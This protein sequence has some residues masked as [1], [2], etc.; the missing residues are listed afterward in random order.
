MVSMELIRLTQIGLQ[1]ANTLVLCSGTELFA[2]GRCMDGRV[3]RRS[4][5]QVP[6]SMERIGLRRC[7][8]DEATQKVCRHNLGM[9]AI[10]LFVDVRSDVYVHRVSP[11]M[12]LYLSVVG[13]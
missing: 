5:V 7:L 1:I 3:L 11:F 13:R 4:S 6:S 2:T 12:D 9:L 8:G 10:D